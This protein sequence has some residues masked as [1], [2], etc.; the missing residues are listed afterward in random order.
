M[1][2][3]AGQ[4]RISAKSSIACQYVLA[5]YPLSKRAL[6]VSYPLVILDAVGLVLF[7]KAPRSGIY[8]N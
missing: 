7:V 4:V 5:G 3:G 1:F 2:E 8:I 6:C